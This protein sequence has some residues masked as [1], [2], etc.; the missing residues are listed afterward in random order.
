MMIP[1]PS[2]FS[3]DLSHRTRRLRS[4]VAE[5][6]QLRGGDDAAA[7]RREQARTL[8]ASARFFSPIGLLTAGLMALDLPGARGGTGR[9]LCERRGARSG[10]WRALGHRRRRGGDLAFIRGSIALLAALGA[11]WGGLVLR[12]TADALATHATLVIPTAIMVALISAPMI[13]APVG[14]ALAFWLPLVIASTVAIAGLHGPHDGLTLALFGSYALFTLGGICVSNFVLHER[15]V[16]RI[17]RAG[18]RP[19]PPGARPRHHQRAAGRGAS[20][21]GRLELGDRRGGSPVRRL[22][23]VGRPARPRPRRPARPH[24]A[25][26]GRSRG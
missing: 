19:P 6:A 3:L 15:S 2:W 24:P 4:F 16:G 25:G 8:L 13:L 1:T 14:A 23:A 5:A 17:P 26:A 11:C 10:A 12:L 21:C 20:R 18:G 7:L 9:L 22:A